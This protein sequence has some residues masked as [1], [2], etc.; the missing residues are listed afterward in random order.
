[1]HTK[2]EKT[3][4]PNING[5]NGRVQHTIAIKSLSS[6]KLPLPTLHFQYFD[7]DKGRLVALDHQPDRPYVIST[8]LRW[9]I[10]SS[11]VGLLTWI[12]I[13]IISL[14]RTH[15][16]LRQQRQLALSRIEHAKSITELRLSLKLIAD[17]EGW[18]TNLSLRDL[19]IYWN[20]TFQTEPAF[21]TLRDQL[22]TACYENPA[23]YSVEMPTFNNLR[24]D[25][26]SAYR[27]HI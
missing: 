15:Y 18:P 9:L 8:I 19:E 16:H 27:S 20:Q 13:R 22:S 23:G 2:T 3:I 25:L 17:A 21:S 5:S 11:L 4:N 24:Q 12:C 26:V 6:G 10:G 1:L 14:I 7:P